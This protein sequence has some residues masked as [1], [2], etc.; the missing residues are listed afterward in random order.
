MDANTLGAHI[1]WAIAITV[2]A[3]SICIASVKQTK[4]KGK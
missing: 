1:N 4:I 2:I 3:I